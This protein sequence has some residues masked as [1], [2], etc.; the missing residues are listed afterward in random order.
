MDSLL[1]G[2]Y[3]IERRIGEGG[4]A[5]VLLARDL[6]EDGRPVVVKRCRAHLKHQPEFAHLFLR[7]ARL[8][9]LVHH[10]NVVSLEATGDDEGQ[11]YL[12]MEYLQ[13]FTVRDIFFR[14]AT[15]GGI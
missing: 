8:A 11:P 2:R 13:G 3:A 12:V 15:E 4:M 14:A 6:A 9:S 1:G 5:E 7:E 10:P